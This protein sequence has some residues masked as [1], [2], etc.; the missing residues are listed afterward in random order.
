ME[1]F[2]KELFHQPERAKEYFESN[3]YTFP[4]NI[5]E[6]LHLALGGS[7]MIEMT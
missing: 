2:Y 5:K 1:Q 6:V 4:R 7:H 3:I